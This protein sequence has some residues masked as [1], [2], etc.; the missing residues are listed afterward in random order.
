MS[1]GALL[2]Q[3]R[4]A[5]GLTQEALAERAGIS[6]DGIGALE[7]GTN[8]A[9]QRDTLQLLIKALKLDVEQERALAALAIRSSPP[10]EYLRRR[11]AIH[12]LPR[13]LTQL[14][15]RERE[16]EEVARLLSASPLVTLIGTGGVGKTR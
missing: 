10:R 11:T 9:P 8:H 7:R 2:R 14:L 16:I 1:F 3:F 4:V 12:N 6:A 15:G 5:A 13:A